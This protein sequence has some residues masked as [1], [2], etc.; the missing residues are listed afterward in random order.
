MPCEL[1]QTTTTHHQSSWTTTNHHANHDEPPRN[2][3]N[4]DEPPRN[5][6][7]HDEPWRTMTKHEPWNITNHDKPWRNI[8][9]HDEPPRN[10]TNH[11]E[12]S[13]TMT[14]HHET[15]RTTTKHHEPWQTT[16][17]H[18][19]LWWNTMWAIMNH[20]KI[21]TPYSYPFLVVCKY[22]WKQVEGFRGGCLCLG[23]GWKGVWDGCMRVF[24]PMGERVKGMGVCKYCGSW[25]KWVGVGFCVWAMGEG[26]WRWVS[27]SA[28]CQGW[29]NL[30]DRCLWVLGP[31]V[32]G[33]KGECLQVSGDR[34][35]EFRGFLSMCVLHTHYI[36]Y[37]C[38]CNHR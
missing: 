7:N 29:K 1:W 31:W 27:V 36:T 18:H 26:V 34:G 19:K 22:W 16:T 15:L 33:L 13:R 28:W 37:I 21:F 5:I 32:K 3:T 10:I 11:H 38:L 20:H 2:I 30:G 17:K 14:N 12:T 23:H 35:E 25:V 6:M 4:H 8:T 24:G 9:N